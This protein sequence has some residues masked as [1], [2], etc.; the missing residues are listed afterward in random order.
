MRGEVVS[1]VGQSGCGKTTL[2]KIAAGLLVPTKGHVAVAGLPA[3]EASAQ[4]K[5]GM[6]FQ[7]ECFFHGARC[8]KTFCYLLNYTWLN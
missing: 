5:F 8:E 3:R 7:I 6:V 2:L 4:R 1:I